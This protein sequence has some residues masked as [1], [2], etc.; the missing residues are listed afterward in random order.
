MRERA[1]LKQINDLGLSKSHNQPVIAKRRDRPAQ[2]PVRDKALPDINV[3][4]PLPADANGESITMKIA[5]T[6]RFG[7]KVRRLGIS[8]R[9]IEN[10]ARPN[11]IT[12]KRSRGPS[13]QAAG[14]FRMLGNLGTTSPAVPA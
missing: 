13:Y 4:G 7:T 2:T 8:L 9:P 11:N 14:L 12:R 6:N 1:S 10:N 3:T 5:G